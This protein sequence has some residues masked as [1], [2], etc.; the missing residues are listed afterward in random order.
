MLRWWPGHFCVFAVVFEGV[1][2]K[3]GCRT[4]FL[5]GEFVVECVVNVVAQ[6]SVF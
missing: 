6:L 2:E 3:M 5:G 4:W 1:L